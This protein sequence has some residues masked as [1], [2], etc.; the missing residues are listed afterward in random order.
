MM[1]IGPNG[2]LTANVRSG[3]AHGWDYSCVEATAHLGVSPEDLDLLEG[4]DVNSD[5]LLAWCRARVAESDTLECDV[6][7]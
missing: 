3:L 2:G 4:T 6:T 5:A 1:T 7:P